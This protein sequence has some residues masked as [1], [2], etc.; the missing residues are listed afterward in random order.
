[1]PIRIM[2]ADDAH[3]VRKSLRLLLSEQS[4]MVVVGDA[5]DG[6]LAVEMAERLRPDVI[7]MDIDMPLLSGIEATR[8]ICEKLPETKVIMLTLHNARAYIRS[9][10]K[11][12]AS[13][14]VLKDDM[15]ADVVP[16][17]RQVMRGLPYF[18]AGVQGPGETGPSED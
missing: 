15:V 17:V 1:M 18:S 6:C 2:V 4:D 14:Y 7:F 5:E 16:A 9:S 13:G 12:G 11:A 8:R 10:M 3:L